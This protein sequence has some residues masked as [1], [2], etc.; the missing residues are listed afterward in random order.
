MLLQGYVMADSVVLTKTTNKGEITMANI[1]Q[2]VAD[3]LGIVKTIAETSKIANKDTEKLN[4]DVSQ[5]GRVVVDLHQTTKATHDDT[6]K[7]ENNI[8]SLIAGQIQMKEYNEN[9]AKIITTTVERFGTHTE[10]LQAITDILNASNKEQAGN[11]E[12]LLEKLDM[13]NNEYSQNVGELLHELQE[14]NTNIAKLDA[15][16]TLVALLK[17][18]TETT[19]ALSDVKQSADSYHSGTLT[20]LDGIQSSLNQAIDKLSTLAE[21]AQEINDDFKTSISRLNVIDLKLGATES[22]GMTQKG[23]TGKSV[24]MTSTNDKEIEGE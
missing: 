18:V 17:K 12:A 16:E 15:N 24:D 6:L 22:D 3:T 14:T 4:E 8:K 5:L 13:S 19:G 11:K 20:S 10:M 9:L 21:R 2:K 7:Q 1:E 23:T